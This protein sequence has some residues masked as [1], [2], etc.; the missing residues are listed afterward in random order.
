MNNVSVRRCGAA[1]CTVALAMVLGQSHAMAADIDFQLSGSGISATGMLSGNYVSLSGFSGDVFEVTGATGTFSDTTDGLSGTFS[2][3][4]PGMTYTSVPSNGNHDS[5]NAPGQPASFDNILYPGGNSPVVCD[6]IFYP[7]HGGLLDIYGLMLTTN[8]TGAG[9]GLVNIW[10][11][12][13]LPGLGLD[14]GVSDGLLTT[15]GGSPFYQIENY[16]GNSQLP[17]YA[18]SGVSVTADVPEPS[19]LGMLGAI[20]ASV[21]LLRMRRKKRA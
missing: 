13:N 12:G 4:E 10:S 20:A 1:A 2:G 7:F 3:V 5:I 19:A 21:P 11:N 6:P 18:G 15:S 9:Q 14:W 8:L 16:V 17:A